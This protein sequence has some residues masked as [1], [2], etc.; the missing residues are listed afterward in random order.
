[1]QEYIQRKASSRERWIAGMRRLR[2]KIY[3]G[4]AAG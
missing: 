3:G 2:D 1:V 4:Q